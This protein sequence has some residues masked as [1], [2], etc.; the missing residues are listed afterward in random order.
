M[1]AKEYKTLE[2]MISAIHDNSMEQTTRAFTIRIIENDLYVEG[3]YI[4]KN[5]TL[6]DLTALLQ[7]TSE[8]RY[9]TSSIEPSWKKE[10]T[11]TLY[12]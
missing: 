10:T 2:E 3:K 12:R 9:G 8:Q 6:S 11:I 4:L 7:Y 1:N 5:C